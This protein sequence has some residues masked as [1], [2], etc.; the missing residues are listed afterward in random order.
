MLQKGGAEEIAAWNRAVERGRPVERPRR[1]GFTTP[2]RRCRSVF[3]PDGAI[4][5]ENRADAAFEDFLGHAVLVVLAAA[6]LTF[7]LPT[8]RVERDSASPLLFVFSSASAPTNPMR[9]SLLSVIAVLLFC[10]CVLAHFQQEP[11]LPRQGAAFLGG[12]EW[13]EPEPEGR[14]RRKQ[15]LRSPP[16][17]GIGPKQCLRPKGKTGNARPGRTLLSEPA[18]NGSKQ[19]AGSWIDRTAETSGHREARG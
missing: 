19:T 1:T 18:D 11:S 6:Q 3:L 9:V 2:N 10:P 4:K 16:G 7:D 12:P 17:A 14:H 5:F 13:G 8:L 15:K